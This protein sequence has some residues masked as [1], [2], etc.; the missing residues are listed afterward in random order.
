MAKALPSAQDLGVVSV[1]PTL[2]TASYKGATG[3]ED[4]AARGLY[5]AGGQFAA[6][7]K[8]MEEAQ[9]KFDA[10]LTGI[11]KTIKR[12]DTSTRRLGKQVE[13]GAERG[14]RL[15]AERKRRRTSTGTRAGR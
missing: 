10:T 12:L 9:E 4:D 8:H 2:G 7:G 1:Q 5:A 15:G 14:T 6:V 11:N 3:G 13:A